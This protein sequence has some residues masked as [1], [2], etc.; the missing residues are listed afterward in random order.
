MK[1]IAQEHG[2]G[3]GVA[4]VAFLL[5]I[6]YKQA[7]ELFDKPANAWSKEY[8]CRDIVASLSKANRKYKSSLFKLTKK[9]LLGL[10]NIIVYIKPSAAYP[11]GHYLAKAKNKWMN[12]WINFPY[13][14]PAKSGFQ[15]EL[16]GDVSYI[17]H[18]IKA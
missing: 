12:P 14:S 18:P 16:P 15:K 13:I 4:S 3:C 5:N 11:A 6:S 10:D 8:Y 2:M 1:S 9:E 17:I 7:L